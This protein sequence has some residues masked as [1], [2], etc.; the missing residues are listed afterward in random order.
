M[1]D[2]PIIFSA[3]MV[4]ALLERHKTQTRRLAYGKFVPAKNPKAPK[5]AG[6][7][8]ETVWTKAQ[9][10]DRLYVR[11][12]FRLR[13]DQDD[14]PPSEDYWKSGAW[15][16]ADGSEPTGC[17]GGPGKLRPSIHMPRWASRL[18][19]VVTDV[20]RERLQEITPEDAMA[21]GIDGTYPDPGPCKWRHPEQDRGTSDPCHAFEW[22]WDSIHGPD[23]WDENPEVCAISFQVISKNIDAVGQEVGRG[24]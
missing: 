21:E 18:T 2:R 1:T 19:L 11:E 17:Q 4:R 6:H 9:P 14:K 22:L 3:P 20:R 5:G 12:N 24:T 7:Y 23:A 13:A 15:Y 16:A 10:G 8:K